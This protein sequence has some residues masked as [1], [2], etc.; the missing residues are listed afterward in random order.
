MATS[1]IIFYDLQYIAFFLLSW[2][3]NKSSMRQIDTIHTI[4]NSF[5]FLFGNYVYR[6]HQGKK[7][8]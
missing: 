7:I 8:E 1:R 2:T 4:F 3:S 6:L 5:Y